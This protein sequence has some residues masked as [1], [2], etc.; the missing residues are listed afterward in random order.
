VR[1]DVTIGVEERGLDDAAL[2]ALAE[3]HAAAPPARL[4]ARVL[5][6]AR[7][8]ARLGR[9]RRS[10]V[11]WRTGGALAAGLAVVLGTSLGRELRH[12]GDRSAEL[13]A[14]AE[15]NRALVARLEAQDRTLAGLRDALAAQAD[16][17]RVLGGPRTLSAALAP[18]AEGGTARARV[19]LDVTSGETALVLSGLGPAPAGKVYELWA[20]R[21]DRAP[22]PA[23]LFAGGTE[24]AAV[25]G[26][27]LE[28]PAE[29]TAFAVSIEPAGGSPSPAGPVV[30]AGAV[31]G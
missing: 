21:G 15:S 23:G 27:A 28:R 20:I 29:V 12:A 6:A 3:A 16:V 4:R 13:I 7:D 1:E 17:L 30:L 14:L 25:R 5:G 2:E 8:E 22:E 26:A 11:R 18:T 19:L 10:L 31:A 9:A 24:T